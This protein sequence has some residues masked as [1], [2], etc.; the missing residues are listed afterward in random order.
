[1]A[2]I[3]TENRG[4][5]HNEL[6]RSY[7]EQTQAYMN[8]FDT[9]ISR[10]IIG[11]GAQVLYCSRLEGCYIGSKAVVENSTLHNVTILSSE[12]EP[13][14]ISG[15][16]IVRNS[17]VQWNST[18]D[19]MSFVERSLLCD[20][21]RVERKGIVRESV[22][23]PNSCIAEGEV[24]SSLVG[25]FVGFHHQ[26][27]LIAA[28]W[29]HGRGNVAYGANVGSNHTSRLP[30]QE[31]FPGEGMFFGL[32]V[33]VKFPSNFVNAPYSVIA[34]GI[35]THPQRME[36]P[37]SLIGAPRQ[38]LEGLSPAL[39][40][41][42]PGYV[43]IML[44]ARYFSNHEIESW[45]LKHSLF[46]IL[47]AQ[48]K[49]RTRNKSKRMRN[50]STGILYN[51]TDLVSIM[52]SK[53]RR[54]VNSSSHLHHPVGRERLQCASPQSSVSQ[55]VYLD[56]TVPGLG[57]NYMTEKSRISGITTYT[58]FIRLHALEA[59]LRRL[60]QNASSVRGVRSIGAF[61]T[62]KPEISLRYG[63]T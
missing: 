60:E 56:A 7:A 14:H 8:A 51:R 30:D 33:N 1:M 15:S 43:G 4:R 45:M 37:F 59:L 13:S 35:C 58:Y 17:I 19:S 41:V 42:S 55:R 50:G 46:S 61:M 9:R 20:S 11:K 29:P 57:S 25:P 26:S 63:L 27:L 16:S 24:T 28:I 12:E 53:N 6:Q 47:R 40:E 48:T 2:A 36:F 23:G 3:L 62:L 21:C 54:I 32:G 10:I 38:L 52:K 49:F 44:L 22:L 31:L 34:S 18:I 5:E 39:N